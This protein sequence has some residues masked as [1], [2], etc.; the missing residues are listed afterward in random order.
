MTYEGAIWTLIVSC[1]GILAILLLVLV[2]VWYYRP[3]SCPN[4]DGTG[5][6]PCEPEHGC[7]G[8][9]GSGVTVKR[10]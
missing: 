10:R 3:R 1:G 9:D 2:S 7:N 4:C 6:D 5:I 8:C